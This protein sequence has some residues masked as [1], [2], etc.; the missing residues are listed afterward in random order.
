M[1]LCIGDTMGSGTCF[2]DFD[3]FEPFSAKVVRS[4]STGREICALWLAA[5]RGSG[6]LCYDW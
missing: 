2:D 6:C 5:G 1:D 3:C 4:T